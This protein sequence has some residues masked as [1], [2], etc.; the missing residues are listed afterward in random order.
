MAYLH[1]YTLKGIPC[2]FRITNFPNQ[3]ISDGERVFGP[4]VEIPKND[5]ETFTDVVYRMLTKFNNGDYDD[6][7]IDFSIFRKS[8]KFDT[9]K[10]HLCKVGRFRFILSQVEHLAKTQ[11]YDNLNL[12]KMVANFLDFT[13]ESS[14]PFDSTISLKY[15]MFDFDY[16][17]FKPE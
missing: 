2:Y 3:S 13:S 17:R 9:K 5:G 7:E 16:Q 4:L 1:L 8:L 10:T 12:T 11:K 14:M 15:P 6:I